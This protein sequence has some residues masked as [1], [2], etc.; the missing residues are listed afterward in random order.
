MHPSL[1]LTLERLLWP[2]PRVRWEAARSLAKLIRSGNKGAVDG[3]VAWIGERDLESEALLGLGVIHAFDLGEY[4]LEETVRRSIQKPSLLSEWMLR[5]N[6]N[7][8]DR[9]AVF[10][11]SISP[12]SSAPV[13]ENDIAL[14]ERYKTVAVAPV[15][16]YR[17]ER[18][19]MDRNYGFVD[20]WRHDWAWLQQTNN[21]MAPDTDFF[22][23]PDGRKSGMLHMAQGEL[24]VSAYLRT[25]AYAMHVGKIKGGEAE[26]QAML[27][28]PINRGLADVE[29]TACPD[30]SR[31]LL[32]R[33]R[34][35]RQKLVEE[36]WRDAQKNV[37][38]LERP[39]ALKVIE[40]NEK[41]FIEVKVDIVIGRSALNE[42]EPKAEAPKWNWV[43]NEAGS[44]AGD[45]HLCADMGYDLVTPMKL[46]C[47][48]APRH[49]G[50]IDAGVALEVKLACLGL[51]WQLGRVDCRADCIELAIGEEVQSRWFHWYA[52]WEPT[53]HWNL[54]S[55]ICC[56]TTTTQT[57]VHALSNSPGI[58][59][60]LLAQVR[61]GERKNTH[62]DHK[63]EEDRFWIK[64]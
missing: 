26:K 37:H 28:L 50:R 17:L 10:R 14:F 31:N 3:L 6:F 13:G 54:D 25:L 9:S 24:L 55:N 45:I 63:I 58:E 20:R 39:A 4:F 62:Y 33:W 44:M 36:I 29:P 2:V 27:A 23:R 22:F 43:N 53:K 38:A 59:V 21:A 47:R 19:G 64:G 52:N 41:D 60:A 12:N 51:G 42:W 56:M 8:D 16:L 15:F 1:G 7:K 32:S 5:K 18:L 48:V 11:F 34:E 46:G 61:L 30:W 35:S 57:L 49:V 40:S